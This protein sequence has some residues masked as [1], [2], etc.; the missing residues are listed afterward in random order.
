MIPL[1]RRVRYWSG[2]KRGAPT[3]EA[4]VISRVTVLDKTRCQRIRK[5]DGGSDYIALTHLELIKPDNDEP[6]TH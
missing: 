4:E 3:G 5:D 6:G 1:S 2:A